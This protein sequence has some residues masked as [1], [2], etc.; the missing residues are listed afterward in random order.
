VDFCFPF[1]LMHRRKECKI[2]NDVIFNI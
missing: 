2:D 1:I